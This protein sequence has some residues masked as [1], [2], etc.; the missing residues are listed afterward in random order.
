MNLQEPPGS[1][2]RSEELDS[3]VPPAGKTSAHALICKVLAKKLGPTG[4]AG[5]GTRPRTH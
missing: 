3:G 4:G 1:T 5:E 2:D